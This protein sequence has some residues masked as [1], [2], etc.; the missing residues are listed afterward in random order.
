MARILSWGAVG[1]GWWKMKG[2]GDGPLGIMRGGTGAPEISKAPKTTQRL[3]QSRLPGP[4][5]TRGW[6][7]VPECRRRVRPLRV[8]LDR[9]DRSGVVVPDIADPARHLERALRSAGYG[10]SRGPASSGEPADILRSLGPYTLH[11]NRFSMMSIPTG[12]PRRSTGHSPRTRAWGV[13]IHVSALC[14]EPRADVAFA[15]M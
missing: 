12:L 8:N 5:R 14:C 2:A 6:K 4:L 9:F 13:A 15:T 7:S 10:H 3:D 11:S 1:D